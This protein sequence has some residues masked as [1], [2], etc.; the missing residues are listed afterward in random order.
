[1]STTTIDRRRARDE[2][3]EPE[4][5]ID[6]RIADRR[7]AVQREHRRK[8]LRTLLI[9]SLVTVVALAGVGLTR[10]SALDVD[11]VDVV[12]ADRTAVDGLIGASGISIGAP[13]TELDLAGARQAIEGLP[14]IAEVRVERQWPNRISIAVRERVP[15][16][17]VPAAE[18]QWA[19]VDETGQVLTVAPATSER[20]VR[21]DGLELAGEP[22]SRLGDEA[23]DPL[24]V[25]RTLPPDLRDG[26]DRIVVDE[27]G[28]LA[29]HFS[30]GPKARLG[31]IDH[32]AEKLGAVASVFSQVDPCGLDVIDVRAVDP[33]SVTRVPSCLIGAPT[34][35]EAD[36]GTAATDSTGAVDGAGATIP[37]GGAEPTTEPTSIGVDATDAGD[38]DG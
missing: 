32:L 16:A 1:V 23:A 17:A 11:H 27:R 3:D 12:G 18:G 14:W 9:L 19:L 25:A 33:I 2:I 31:G 5:D 28:E 4:L 29:L 8:R 13:M 20:W 15:V 7:S 21:I 6:P 36:T 35:G 22:G 10:S 24:E 30:T 26:L 37:A 38:V 34:E